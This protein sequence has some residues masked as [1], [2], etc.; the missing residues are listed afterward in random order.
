MIMEYLKSLPWVTDLALGIDIF[1]FF[2]IGFYIFQKYKKDQTNKPL[3][4]FS[5]YF[6]FH[7]LFVF[8]II[9]PDFLM[10]SGSFA[11]TYLGF[12]IGLL[13]RAYGWATLMRI[14]AYLEWPKHELKLFYGMLVFHLIPWVLVFLKPFNATY[15]VSMHVKIIHIHPWL[16]GIIFLSMAAVVFP[17]I[18]VFIKRAIK[19]PKPFVKTRALLLAVGFLLLLASGPMHNFGKTAF[20]FFVIEIATAISALV[21]FTG[22]IYRQK[23]VSPKD[24]N[25]QPFSLPSS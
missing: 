5:K 1:L 4:Y 25:S 23:A 16:G 2:W 14:P 10:P 12:G 6:F 17:F 18:Y 24:T 11:I 22:I 13:P 3:L 20:Q 7:G 21:I 19:S 15:D 8:F 9:L